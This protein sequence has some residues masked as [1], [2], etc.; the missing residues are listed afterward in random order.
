[1]GTFQRGLTLVEAMVTVAILGIL[2]AIALPSYNGFIINSR[3]KGVAANVQTDLQYARS[4]ATQG[5]ENVTVVFGT[6][7]YAIYR[8]TTTST[9]CT[10]TSALKN[11]SITTADGVSLSS[12][13]TTTEFNPARGTVTNTGTITVSNGAAKLAASLGVTGRTK[14]CAPSDS[15]VGGFPAC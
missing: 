6:N 8:G 4:V 11:V 14:L 3:V 7:C 15:T 2:A 5:N 1:M 10:D 9:S 12:T 13:F